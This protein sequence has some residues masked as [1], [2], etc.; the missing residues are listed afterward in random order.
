MYELRLEA[1]CGQNSEISTG[2]ASS[3]YCAAHHEVAVGQMKELCN[4]GYFY[5]KLTQS[6]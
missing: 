5:K 2:S 4:R 6:K 1:P 3:V